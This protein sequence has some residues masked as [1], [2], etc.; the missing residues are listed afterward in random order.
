MSAAVF[1]GMLLFAG[2][3]FAAEYRSPDD[4]VPVEVSLEDGEYSIE[5]AMAGGS[6]RASV[7]SPTF[8][9]VRNG[10]A[11]V[12]LLWSSPYYDYMLV[13]NAYFGNL[14]TDGGNSEFEIPVTA[15][16]EPVRVVADTTAMGEPV[17]IEYTLT[18]YSESIGSK[19][20]V[21]QEAAKRVIIIAVIIIAGGGVLNYFIQK[22][23]RD[24]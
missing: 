17:E 4:L 24:G 21:P 8:L 13:D 5:A 19:G 11:Y 14:T 2:R 6:G 23:R 15:M 20:R 7:S 9:I 22:K 12:R 10:K 18:F 16:D 1:C 3:A